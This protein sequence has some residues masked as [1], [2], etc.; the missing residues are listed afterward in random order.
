MKIL[1]ITPPEEELS[2]GYLP[3]LGLGYMAAVLENSGHKVKIIDPHALGLDCNR[4]IKRIKEETPELVGITAT[5]HSRFNAI[6]ILEG[7]KE[8]DCLKVVGGVHFS[9]SDSDALQRTPA[10]IVVRGEGEYTLLD[11]AERK[12]LDSIPGI[13]YRKNKQIIR[14]KERQ[15]LDVKK[16]PHPARHLFPM[17]KYNTVLEGEGKTKC[18][19]ILTSRGCPNACVFCANSSYWR[20]ILRLRD[21][22]DVVDEI[23]EVINT[24]GIRGFDFWDD[25]LTVVPRHVEQICNEIIRRNLDIAWYARIRVNTVNRSLLELMKRAGCVALS[26][27][28]ES[29]SPRVLKEINKNIT[30]D[31]AEKV[32]KICN[33]LGFHTKAFFMFNLPTETLDDVKSTL[34]FMNKLDNSYHNMIIISGIT[35]V[36]PG[37]MIEKIAKIEGILP[38]VFSW[39]SPYN[40]EK[41]HEY[42]ISRI[43]RIVPPFEYIPLEKLI[44]FIERWHRRRALINGFKGLVQIRSINDFYNYSHRVWK[45]IKNDLG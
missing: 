26:F 20:R 36:Y 42:N 13:T 30:L 32:A 15:F 45:Y 38:E 8:L 19:S 2:K 10:D 33:E 22:V 25:T 21:P 7:I 29:G 16:L 34:K 41:Y 17:E 31:Q 44:P 37:T 14:N 23:E 40:F 12:P 24:Y 28:V 35:L 4:V 3:P 27:G 43:S 39:N 5:S 6:K 9:F 1:L 18:T 11:I